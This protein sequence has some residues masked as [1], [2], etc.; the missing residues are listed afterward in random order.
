MEGLDKTWALN[1]TTQSIEAEGHRALMDTA[2]SSAVWLAFMVIVIYIL[3]RGIYNLYFHPL[4]K[5]PGPRVAAVSSL[6]DFWYDVVKGGT[7]LWEIRKMHEVYGNIQC[8]AFLPSRALSHALDRSYRSHQPERD[9][10][11]RS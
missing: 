1:A 2:H 6:Y 4:C 9:T 7:Y 3:S 5:I 11:Q 10:H 8:R